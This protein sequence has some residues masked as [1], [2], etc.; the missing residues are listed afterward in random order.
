MG[1]T[2]NGYDYMVRNIG[3]PGGADLL[4]IVSVA[5][6]ATKE[7]VSKQLGVIGYGYGAYLACLSLTNFPD[8]F[9]CGVSIGGIAD[10]LDVYRNSDV[11]FK[12][13]I[14]M[15]FD[16]TPADKKTIMEERS[17][18][19]NLERMKAPLCIIHPINDTRVPFESFLHFQTELLRLNKKFEAHSVENINDAFTVLSPVLSFLNRRLR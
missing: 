7:G 14:E 9:S 8:V 13:F 2:G 5:Q 10:W 17:V 11:T 3:D 1:S 6:S 4:D 18:I 19:T 15:L 12:H 16:G